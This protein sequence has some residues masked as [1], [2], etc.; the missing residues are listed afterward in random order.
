MG[1]SV[2]WSTRIY[3]GSIISDGLSRF[4]LFL[5]PSILLPN[6]LMSP[7]P[8]EKREGSTSQQGKILKL[9][10]FPLPS[11][12]NLMEKRVEL[13]CKYCLCVHEPLLAVAPTTVVKLLSWGPLHVIVIIFTS[14]A[15]P[16]WAGCWLI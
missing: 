4:S 9:L 7:H 8:R 12:S 3:A 13:P 6:L 2:G 14:S 10:F 15:F 16:Q 11:P 5:L 1:Q